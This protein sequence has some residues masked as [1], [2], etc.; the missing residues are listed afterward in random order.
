MS[1]SKKK[2]KKYIC[3]NRILKN[4]FYKYFQLIN[5]LKHLFVKT[6]FL[7]L[8]F[9]SDSYLSASDVFRF[10]VQSRNVIV[11]LQFPH[12]LFTC[13]S[14]CQKYWT[15]IICLYTYISSV[16]N[17]KWFKITRLCWLHY[18]DSFYITL[19]YPTIRNVTRQ[20]KLTHST[21]SIKS[22]MSLIV[23]SDN[24]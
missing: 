14:M 5:I 4:T 11:K 7:L 8:S 12:L 17:F 9:I 18:T 15:N 21:T 1:F 10:F 24:D 3:L 6:V 16:T 13:V 19:L 2:K 22:T 20:N 23:I